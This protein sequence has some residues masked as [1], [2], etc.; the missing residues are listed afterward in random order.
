MLTEKSFIL[1]LVIFLILNF[2]ALGLGALL[3]GSGPTGEWYQNLNCAPWTPPGWVFGAAWFTIMLT[4]S[5]YM[6]FLAGKPGILIYLLF[7]LQ[8]VLNVSW[9]P[10]FF[11]LRMPMLALI[12]I[13]T[14]AVV[15]TLFGIIYWP[16]LKLKSLLILPYFIW[17]WIAVSLNAYIVANNQFG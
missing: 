1:R 3:Q 12:I 10:V 17:L 11:E 7:G 9:N 6:A 13:V 16:T 4:F 5:F 15:I 14:L 8:W 2:G